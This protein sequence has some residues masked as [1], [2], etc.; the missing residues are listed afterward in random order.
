MQH[1]FCTKNLK[2][3]PSKRF[4]KKF[5]EQ[6]GGFEVWIGVRKDESAARK[7]RY[8]GCVGEELVAP[9]DFMEEYPK[10]LQKMGVMF[11][12]PVI[13]WSEKDVFEYL[14]GQEN[15]LYSHGSKRVGCYPCLAAGDDQMIDAFSHDDF[16]RNQWRKVQFLQEKTGHS[17]LRGEVGG[18][19]CSICSM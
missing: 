18:N 7:K 16:G 4:Y 6:H 1:R 3:R 12:L 5:A 17:A 10:F 13:D 2:V 15:P 9:N 11:R 8:A 19:G 14:D